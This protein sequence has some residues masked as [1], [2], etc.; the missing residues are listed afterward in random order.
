MGSRETS[1]TDFELQREI[2]ACAAYIRVL[3]RIDDSEHIRKLILRAQKRRARA[4]R[5]Q[6]R[7]D[8]ENDIH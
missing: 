8:I 5:E 1:M 2:E 7:R 3:G 6:A 4:V